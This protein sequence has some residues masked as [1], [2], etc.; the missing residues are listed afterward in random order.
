MYRYTVNG[1][2]NGICC[3]PSFAAGY[4]VT[5]LTSSGPLTS[6]HANEYNYAWRHLHYRVFQK[7]T[8][9]ILSA[10]NFVRRSRTCW[11]SETSSEPYVGNEQP[12]DELIN[13]AIDHWFKWLSFVVRSATTACC[14]LYLC[15][16]FALKVLQQVLMFLNSS[17]TRCCNN[18]N[19][20]IT[21]VSFFRVSIAINLWTFGE[22]HV[23][24]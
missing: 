24:L 19:R 4:P 8:H 1:Y 3:I 20:N 18:K 14:K 7:K 5:W 15:Q 21:T 10:V 6:G 17:F 9:K 12:I 13:D 22:N 16:D 23:T 2:G 11:P